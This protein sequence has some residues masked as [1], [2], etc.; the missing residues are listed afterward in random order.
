MLPNVKRSLF[1]SYFVTF[2]EVEA[3]RLPPGPK[4]IAI[5]KSAPNNAGVPLD[6]FV[7]FSFEFSSWPDF[8]GISN[9][10]IHMGS[11]ILKIHS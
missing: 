1:L 2:L 9:P 7:S 3:A 5:P 4:S 8:A 11:L 6:S 10:N